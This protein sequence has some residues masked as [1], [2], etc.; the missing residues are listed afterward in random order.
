MPVHLTPRW[1]LY[2]KFARPTLPLR[3]KTKPFSTGPHVCFVF[4]SISASAVTY[5]LTLRL[6]ILLHPSD[7]I[8]LL[9]LMSDQD[10]ISPYN[11]NIISNRQVTRIKKILIRGLL[12]LL[13][14]NSPN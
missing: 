5:R 12:V 6:K 7:C 9:T 2:Q 11:I 14:P 3:L 4:I 1:N 8:N 10:R 13:I